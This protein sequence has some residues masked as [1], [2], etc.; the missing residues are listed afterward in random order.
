MNKQVMMF[1]ALATVVFLSSA[2]AQQPPTQPISAAACAANP[3]QFWQPLFQFPESPQQAQDGALWKVDYQELIAKG[4]LNADQANFLVKGSPKAKESQGKLVAGYVIAFNGCTQQLYVDYRE[5]EATAPALDQAAQNEIAKAALNVA[6]AD[7]AQQQQQADA[8]TGAV[9]PG[10]GPSTG[11]QIGQSVASA[12]GF[13]NPLAVLTAPAAG[14]I[15]DGVGKLF[16]RGPRDQVK[17]K[18][19]GKFSPSGSRVGFGDSY[20]KAYETPTRPVCRLNDGVWH[21][22]GECEIWVE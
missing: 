1:F 17:I 13:L 21:K 10:A 19:A 7:T 2:L 3:G 12:A 6:A 18:G 11:R 15:G 22:F 8:P 9:A 4:R 14:F 5:A 20:S 16:A